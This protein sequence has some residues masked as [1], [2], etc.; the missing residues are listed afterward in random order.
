MPPKVP[1]L[2]GGAAG[3]PASHAGS[4]RPAAMP[5]GREGRAEVSAA[6]SLLEAALEYA[7]RGWLV[8]PLHSH[9]EAGCSCGR[10]DCSSPAKHPRTTRGLKDAACDPAVIRGWWKRWPDANVGIATGAESG[11]VVLDV[12][13]EH[14]ER[15]ITALE[16]K[17]GPLPDTY[18]VRT[19]GGGYHH[20]F[21]LPDGATVRNSASRIAPGLDVRG[22]GG[23][24]VAPPSL[25]A[26]GGRYEV[27]ESAILPVAAP[28]WLL[29]LI[30]E[31]EGAQDGQSEPAAGTVGSEPI[32]KGGRTARLVSL[33]G[34]MLKR[35]MTPS[36]IEAGLLAE[37][38][39]KCS[40]PLPEGKVRSIARDI[41]A[42]YPAGHSEAPELPILQPD[43]VRLADVAARPV[44]WLWEPFLP[45]GMLTM[46]SG[47]PGTGKSFIALSIAADLTRG[48]LRDARIIEPASVLYLS[49]ENPL[50]ESIRPRFDM[51]GG[52][53]ARFYALRGTMFAENGE[54]QHGAV[55]LR[56]VPILDSAIRQTGARLV[57]VDPIQS[58]LGA[59]VDLHRSNETRPVM[60]SLSRLAEEHGCAILLLRHLSKQSG[61]KAIHRGL[62]SIDLT[63]AVRSELLAGSLPD[64]PEARALVH[65]KSN[66][67]RIGRTLGYAIDGEGRFTWTGECNISAADLLAAPAEPGDR[68]LADAAEWLTELLK[69]GPREQKEITE[70]AD[71]AG[72][73]DRTLRRAKREIRVHSFRKGFGG[74]WWWELPQRS[75]NP[76]DGQKIDTQNLAAYGELAAYEDG[77]HA[78]KVAKEKYISPLLSVGGQKVCVST[79]VDTYAD[80]LA[81]DDSVCGGL[82]Q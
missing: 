70:L 50:A 32:A 73:K 53:P 23:Y 5:S 67:G 59:N 64:D 76:V 82:V 16:R 28:G 78:S 41:G 25:H 10:V 13:G 21:Q 44:G 80:R 35:G 29:Q 52:D 3:A 46:L 66:V 71:A 68:K 30:R 15:A 55:T 11:I 37:N 26:S 40:P 54:E 39:A 20:Y 81:F 58:Y 69:P 1:T 19:G 56:D 45:T 17:N 47:D 63:G 65:V 2:A 14:G 79:Y 77:Q 27:N 31:P 6:E 24:V 8:L 9:S 43:L 12:D 18:S 48:K 22:N 4:G 74:A 33:A 38:A 42:R 72:I 57:I 62:G 51:L 34:S 49:V 36:A 75:A 61:G 60:D 7:E